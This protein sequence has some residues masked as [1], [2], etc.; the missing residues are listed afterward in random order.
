MKSYL[1][2]W[3]LLSLVL[4]LSSCA[5][6]KNG[7]APKASQQKDSIASWL[8][9][10]EA[11][12]SPKKESLLQKAYGAVIPL[13]E[14]T[15][16]TKHLLALAYAY[17][18]TADTLTA[19]KINKETIQLALKTGDSSSLAGAYWDLGDYL[20]DRRYKIDSGFY[21]YAQAQRLY[22]GLGNTYYSAR[23]L[24]NMAVGQIDI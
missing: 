17:F 23:M 9:Q 22:E 18:D 19:R 6:T 14:D 8:S 15:V 16:K 21:Y 13:P 5:D 24:I 3:Y 1:T 2:Y 20:S 11:A 12:V 10:A 4:I 7:T